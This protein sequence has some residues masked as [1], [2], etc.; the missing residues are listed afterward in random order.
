MQLVTFVK[1]VR[2]LAPLKKVRHSMSKFGKQLKKSETVSKTIW[3]E[4]WHTIHNIYKC[5][6]NAKQSL[7]TAKIVW[8]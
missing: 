3:N 7:E 4:F 5:Q 1:K 2:E 8:A 6:I